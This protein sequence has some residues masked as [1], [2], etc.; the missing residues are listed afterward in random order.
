QDLHRLVLDEPLL[1][2]P[3]LLATHATVDGDDRLRLADE[4]AHALRDVVQGVAVLGEDDE[5]AAVPVGVE[6]E[7][8]LAVALQDAAQLVPLAV[9]VAGTQPAGLFLE[10]LEDLDLGFQLDEAAGRRG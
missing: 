9:L 4:R 8:A 3:P 6:H 10:T 7:P 1:R 2:G 5:L